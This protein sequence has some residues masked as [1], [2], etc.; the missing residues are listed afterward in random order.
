MDLPVSDS[1][2]ICLITA[3][4]L[5]G[6]LPN[7]LPLRS[8]SLRSDSGDTLVSVRDLDSW[9]GPDI[10]VPTWSALLPKSGSDDSNVVA[11]G[12]T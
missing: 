8:F 3:I 9:S 4:E 1:P 6:L 7:S 5:P 12:D 10:V 2:G 11:E